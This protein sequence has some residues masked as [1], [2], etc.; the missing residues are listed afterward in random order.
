MKQIMKKFILYF[1]FACMAGITTL[2][3]LPVNAGGCSNHKSNSSKVECSENGE[4]CKIDNF[5]KTKKNFS[6]NS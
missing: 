1:A 5:K 2:N 6:I 4:D 3:G